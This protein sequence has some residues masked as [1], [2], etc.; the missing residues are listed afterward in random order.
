MALADV[1]GDGDLDLYVANYRPDTIADMPATTFKVQTVGG[2]P[3]VAQVNGQPAT[4]PQWT[5]R[6]EIG[7]TGNVVELGQPDVLYL[8]D[9]KGRFTPVS[10]TDGSFLDE[11][12]QPMAE[13]PRDWGLTVQMRDFNGD[14]APDIYVCN[15]F[16]TPDRIWI[17]DGH[18]K[19][20]ALART[21]V[22]TTSVFSMGVDFADI[23]RDGNVDFFVAD[24]LSPDHR[25][26]HVQLG[27]R[28]PF[29]WP[30]GL[31]DNRPQVS[32]NTLQ[33]NRGDGT[34]AEISWYAGVEATDWSWCPV[35]LDVDL[36]GYEDLLVSNGVLRDFQNIDMA[37]RMDARLGGGKKL[38]QND[39]LQF[40]NNFPTLETPN[41]LYRNKGDWTFEEVSAAWGFA[42]PVVSQGMALAD[43]DNDGDIDV[44]VNNLGRGP[45]VYKNLSNAPRLAVRLKG[46]VGNAQGI[47]AKIFIRG[48]PVEQS[49]E[50][51]CGGR[52]LSGSDALRVFAAGTLTN[53]LQ[54]DVTWRD[55]RHSGLAASPNFLYEI[56]AQAA[57]PSPATAPVKPA[58]PFRGIER[59]RD[60]AARRATL[61]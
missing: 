48:G 34:F 61:R 28:S 41:V 6:F 59:P 12:G 56:D 37:N 55:G 36:D 42:T 24:M 18:G 57:L 4:L 51:I 39:I 40:M 21:A 43:L 44:V 15:D 14:G 53:S 5:N 23:D 52:Y 29:N 7:P 27:G 46:S 50:M 8:N 10:F 13:A 22:R 20:R 33:R 45:G 26:R 2:R 1:D 17:N 11:D 58:S 30:I 9:G 31:V 19:F 54:V 3:A 35:F 47:G 25:K 49:Q 60:R 16:F 38:T 32:R